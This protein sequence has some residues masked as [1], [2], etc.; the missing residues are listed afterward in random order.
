MTILER[1]GRITTNRP[2][3]RVG[4]IRPVVANKLAWP[5]R[6]KVHADSDEDAHAFRNIDEVVAG[7]P[8]YFN[9]RPEAECRQSRISQGRRHSSSRCGRIFDGCGAATRREVDAVC[10]VPRRSRMASA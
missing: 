2:L 4:P 10:L 9:A 1:P 5:Y 8:Q 7:L 6:V 3:R